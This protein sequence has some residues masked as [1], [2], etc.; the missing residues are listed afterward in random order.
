LPPVFAIGLISK[1][2]EKFVGFLPANGPAVGLMIL[3]SLMAPLPLDQCLVRACTGDA[4]AVGQLLDQQRVELRKLAEEQL[5]ALLQQRIDASDVV[6]QTCLSVFRDIRE[7]DGRDPAQFV[8]WVRKIHER[9]IQNAIRDQLQTQR[10][11]AERESPGTEPTGVPDPAPSPSELVRQD[12][13]RQK[14]LGVLLQLPED[15]QAVLRLRYWEDCTLAEICR[16]LNLS[17]D[18]AAWTMHKALRRAKT[19]M[20]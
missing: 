11:A 3:A 8:A 16:R 9:N 6:Q 10:R 19:L 2:L 18:A 17:R 1:K 13:E 12:D 15:E 4:D 20:K 7:F 14:L 5:P